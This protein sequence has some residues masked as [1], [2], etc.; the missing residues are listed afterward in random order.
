MSA[1]GKGTGTARH[2]IDIQFGSIDRLSQWGEG[3][4]FVQIISTCLGGS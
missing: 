4:F 2:I 3:Y 1:Q